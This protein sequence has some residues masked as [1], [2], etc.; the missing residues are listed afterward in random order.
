MK[1]DLSD[2]GI[3]Y[4]LNGLSAL[5]ISWRDYQY[6]EVDVL[7]IALLFKAL[8]EYVDRRVAEMDKESEPETLTREPRKGERQVLGR[9]EFVKTSS[10]EP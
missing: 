9:P 8:K 10:S 5:M 7:K 3:G 4:V 6:T 2:E 1:L